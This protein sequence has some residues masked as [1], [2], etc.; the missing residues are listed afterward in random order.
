MKTEIQKPEVQINT[1]DQKSDEQKLRETIEMYSCQTKTY[2]RLNGAT[3]IVIK[4][5]EYFL[6]YGTKMNTFE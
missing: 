2:L 4:L 5:K 3:G 6:S 1:F